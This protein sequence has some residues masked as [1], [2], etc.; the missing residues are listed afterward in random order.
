MV[1]LI[2][3]TATDDVI[4]GFDLGANKSVQRT[5]STTA[6]SEPGPL[7]RFAAG[8]IGLFDW[9]L[10]YQQTDEFRAELTQYAAREAIRLMHVR[11]YGHN[12]R[13]AL[14]HVDGKLAVIDVQ[15]Q[16]ERQKRRC[17]Y[18]RQKLPRRYDVDHVTPMSRGGRNTPD[19]IVVCCHSCNSRKGPKLLHESATGLLL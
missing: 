10:A 9:L 17:F 16:V 12:R 18:C 2:N 11:V 5:Q 15:A 3:P 13:A 19:N 7:D 1:S 4:A 14:A 6:K 8:E